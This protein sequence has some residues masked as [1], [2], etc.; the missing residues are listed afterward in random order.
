MNHGYFSSRSGVDEWVKDNHY[1]AIG[2]RDLAEYVDPVKAGYLTYTTNGS[3]ADSTD[4]T[5]TLLFASSTMADM[6]RISSGAITSETV[7][8][9]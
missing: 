9:L 4:S 5:A 3:R 1:K 8:R 7:L 6:S 2:L